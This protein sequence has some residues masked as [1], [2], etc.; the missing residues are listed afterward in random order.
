M[1]LEGKE[2]GEKDVRRWPKDSQGNTQQKNKKRNDRIN[3]GNQKKT[4]KNQKN[5]KVHVYLLHL[6]FED[7]QVIRQDMRNQGNKSEDCA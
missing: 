3:Q 1:K 6:L 5:A 7:S 4:P 2:S